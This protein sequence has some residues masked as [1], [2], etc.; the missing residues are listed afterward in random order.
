MACAGAAAA[1]P[2]AMARAIAIGRTVICSPLLVLVMPN[3]VAL[4]MAHALPGRRPIVVVRLA[5]LLADIGGRVRRDR[6][7]ART[8]HQV[9][10]AGFGNVFLRESRRCQR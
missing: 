5:I 3:F 2:A 7:A 6:R 8:L 10:A 9:A 1:K 4:D